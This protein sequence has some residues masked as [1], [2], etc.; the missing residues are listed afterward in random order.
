MKLSR[1]IESA[2]AALFA[3][4]VQAS[5][6]QDVTI[7]GQVTDRL[8]GNPVGA[9]SVELLGVD[10]FGDQS[11]TTDVNGYYSF[12]GVGSLSSP[13]SLS[14]AKPGNYFPT[15]FGDL[16]LVGTSM[17]VDV[18]MRAGYYD[19]TQLGDP[20]PKSVSAKLNNHGEVLASYYASNGLRHG[21][22]W[23][24]GEWEQVDALLGLSTVKNIN[25][26]GQVSCFS[27]CLLSNSGTCCHH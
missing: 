18:T 8:T 4:G 19:V 25:D 14:F 2:V 15:F 1:V 26:M 5:V 3:L 10:Y 27:L 13:W 17:T 22:V 6:A 16:A 9:V 21:F 23:R 7:S 24:G 20:F 12:Q 11:S